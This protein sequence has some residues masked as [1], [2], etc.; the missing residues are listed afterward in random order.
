MVAGVGARRRLADAT[1]VRV[2]D[3]ATVY[4]FFD[5]AF[6]SASRVTAAAASVTQNSPLPCVLGA[7]CNDRE[8]NACSATLLIDAVVGGL[9]A[10]FVGSATGAGNR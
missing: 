1:V 10:Q 3:N 4:T 6:S 9:A 7:G 2:S 8:R 5:V